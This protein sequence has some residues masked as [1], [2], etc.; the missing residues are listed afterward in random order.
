MPFQVL[1]NPEF[2]NMKFHFTPVSIKGVSNH[3][4]LENK[5]CYG[6]DLR[7][8]T[9]ENKVDLKYLI[10]CYKVYPEKDRFFTAYIDKLAGNSQL[11]KQI[12]QGLS[13]EQIRETWKADLE[14]YKAMRMKYLLYE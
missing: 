11:K 3:P 13:E 1:G 14:V 12:M 10:D 8:V 7:S 2:K 4:P 5:L 9:V 6:I